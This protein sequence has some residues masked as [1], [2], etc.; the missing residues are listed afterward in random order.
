M[1]ELS[2]KAPKRRED[3]TEAEEALQEDEAPQAAA[4]PPDE[5]S[6][7]IALPEFLVS[8]IADITCQDDLDRVVKAHQ[9]WIASVFD[10]KAETVA[11]R[12]NLKGADL[13]AFNLEGVNLS[14]ANLEGANL[15]GVEATGINLTAANLRGALL[16]AANL[17][18]ARLTRVKIEGADL[19]GADLTGATLLG[20]DL[21]K[22]IMK[23]PEIAA[24]PAP[25]ALTLPAVADAP[26]ERFEGATRVAP[27]SDGDGW[28]EDA[29]KESPDGPE[30]ASP[31]RIQGAK[32]PG[33]PETPEL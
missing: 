12:A 6:K 1:A 14:G 27:P 25:S 21:A 16:Q 31:D 10:P 28:D 3:L 17:R 24:E 11:G 26:H 18:N 22:A 7:K 29:Q 8:E 23:S 19:C 13:R 32:A 33:H 15:Q 20:V 5:K 30:A 2:G 4:P 9:G